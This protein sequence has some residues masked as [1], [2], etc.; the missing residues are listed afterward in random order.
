[1]VV[2]YAAGAFTDIAARAFASELSQQFGQQFVVDNRTG[3]AGIIGTDIVAKA[4]PDGYTLLVGDNGLTITPALYEKLPYDVM[5]DFTHIGK[6]AESPT[7]LVAALKVPAKTVP[8]LIEL[9]RARPGELTFGSGGTGSAAHLA[10]ELLLEIGKVKMTHVP[11]K[12]VAPS[13]AA[14]VA[15]QIDLSFGSVAAGTP[16]VLAGRVHGLAVSGSS[17]SPLLTAVPTFAEAGYPSY[18]FMHWW[19]MAAPAGVPAEVVERLTQGI[20]VAAASP[21]LVKSFQTQGATPIAGTPAEMR[22]FV[23]TEIDLWRGII[24]RAGIKVE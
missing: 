12:G 14:V 11:F 9:A 7:L 3:G 8:E 19:S 22:P 10:M 20:A 17:R 1:M 18:S 6:I 5:R 23:E 13:V 24:K 15:G 16:H 21:R 2:P 4:N